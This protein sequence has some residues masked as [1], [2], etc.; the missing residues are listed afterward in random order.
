[1][2]EASCA[3]SF[4]SSSH[5]LH[6]SLIVDNNGWVLSLIIIIDINGG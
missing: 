3:L 4:I 2:Y 1:M 5:D 6:K